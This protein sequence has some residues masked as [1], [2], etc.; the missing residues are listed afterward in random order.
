MI[1]DKI[2]MNRFKNILLEKIANYQMVLDIYPE[3][4][5]PE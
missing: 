4:K 3:H 1:Q 5:I 2:E